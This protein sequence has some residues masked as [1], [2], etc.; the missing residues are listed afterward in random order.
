MEKLIADAS[1]RDNGKIYY[2]T[3]AR[4]ANENARMLRKFLLEQP[5]SDATGKSG[6]P[7][8]IA[9]YELEPEK[10][11]AQR[12]LTLKQKRAEW[13]RKIH[14]QEKRRLERR[15][16]GEV[17][18]DMTPPQRKAHMI[19]RQYEN[20][21]LAYEI[22]TSSERLVARDQEQDVYYSFPVEN[23]KIF[24]QSEVD[25]NEFSDIVRE[26]L[27]YKNRPIERTQ[28]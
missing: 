17:M 12:K 23:L 25:A 21:C 2:E 22:E 20:V 14:V 9:L 7:V 5:P 15:K 19:K 1:T 16:D 18:E 6:T 10:E 28:F 8:I 3:I 26:Y 11:P 13:R 24:P 4:L 27:E